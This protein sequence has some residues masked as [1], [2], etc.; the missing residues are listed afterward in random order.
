[1]SISKLS[2]LSVAVAALALGQFAHAGPV[3]SDDFT[4]G[5]DF[6][7]SR[8]PNVMNMPG[9]AYQSNFAGQYYSGLSMDG[10]Q[11]VANLRNGS[12]VAISIASAG[13][14]TKASTITI[15][16]TFS[17]RTDAYTNVSNALGFEPAVAD[18][19]IPA[20]SPSPSFVGLVVGQSFDDGFGTVRL[21]ANGVTSNPQPAAFQFRAGAYGWDNGNYATLTYTVDTTSGS[22][23]AASMTYLDDQGISH[24]QTYDFSA[25][26]VGLFTDAATNYAVISEVYSGYG[27]PLLVKNFSVSAVPEPA[28]LGLLGLGGLS[29]LVRRRQA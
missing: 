29:L 24:T 18:P 27:Q 11:Q 19:S 10:G 25:A 4:T 12:G 16:D 23:Q 3:I 17:L 20:Y 22:I 28:S 5:A 1:M 14:Y 13:G 21:L 9:S 7:S 15:S 6:N 8:L 2:I 26:T